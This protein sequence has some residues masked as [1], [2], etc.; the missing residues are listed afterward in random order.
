MS[1][2]N[3]LQQIELFV[4][5]TL[6]Q[7]NWCGTPEMYLFLGSVECKGMENCFAIKINKTKNFENSTFIQYR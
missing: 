1:P 6:R 2:N 7:I 5:Y 4:Y 3:V